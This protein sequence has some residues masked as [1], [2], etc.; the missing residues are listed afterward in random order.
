MLHARTEMDAMDRTDAAASQQ[1]SSRGM[2]CSESNTVALER[3]GSHESA[4]CV[5]IGI[6]AIGRNEG[7]RLKRCLQSVGRL[8]DRVVYVDSGSSD[9][10]VAFGRRLGVDV[11]ELDLRKPFTAARARN[12]GFRRLLQLHPGLEYVFF[13]DGDCEVV[14]GWLEKASEF[15]RQHLAVALVWGGRR[16]RFPRRSI[17]NELCDLEWSQYPAG[18]T[19]A[20]GGDAL[21]RVHA[22]QQVEGYRADLVC[23]EEPE[24][25]LRL[26]RAGWQI[27]HIEDDMTLHDAALYRFDQWWKRMVRGGYAYA[28]G[29][30]LHGAAP[31]KHWVVESRRAWIWG[32]WIPVL[33]LTLAVV[34]GPLA[35]WLLLVYPL[36]VV[37]LAVRGR[38]SARDNWLRAAA[39]TM[40]K[41]PEM[42][43]QLRFLLDRLRRVQSGLIEYK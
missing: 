33:I 39:L 25:C 41:F 1:R 32:L 9:D 23:G 17:Y 20:C 26:R 37:Q 34:F 21:V 16:E 5:S 11:V 15:L 42:L 14:D 30:A 24:L 10:S 35:L 38:S 12:A 22:L 31:E 27:W 4:A 8:A 13:V 19:K 6:V 18:E 2:A 3:D 28:Q 7:D 40:C 43:G 36:Q 29:A